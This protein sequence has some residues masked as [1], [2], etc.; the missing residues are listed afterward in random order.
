MR[1]S[2]R[3]GLGLAALAFSLLVAPHVSASDGPSDARPRASVS[4]HDRRELRATAGAGVFSAT[5]GGGY[6]LDAELLHRRGLLA[7]A[8]VGDYGTTVF[9]PPRS[10]GAAG[11]A[12]ISIP[13]V[14]W[15]RLDLLGVFGARR[16]EG[17]GGMAL[18]GVYNAGADATLPFMGARAGVALELG[19]DL[20]FVLGIRGAID[21]DLGT[22]TRT[23]T[24]SS[25][26]FR[27][28]REQ[29]IGGTRISGVFTLGG[30]FD[31]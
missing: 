1:T 2:L 28:T 14:S 8:A 25:A 22:V 18:M 31:L 16:Y 13:T 26:F 21:R 9:M 27:D 6:V 19:G 11:G 10:F 7:L 29:T 23:T 30:T 12:G 15:L 17:V 3:L 5:Q 24:A 4:I 20:R